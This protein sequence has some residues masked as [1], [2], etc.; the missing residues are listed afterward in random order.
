MPDADILEADL[1]LMPGPDAR[2]RRPYS[3]RPG[4]KP[5]R[6]RAFRLRLDDATERSP[7]EESIVDRAGIRREFAHRHAEPRADVHLFAR[8]HQ[9]AGLGQLAVDRRPR[10]VFGMKNVLPRH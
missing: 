3:A 2:A 5:D 6:S 1:P 9:P 7:D 4:P 10:A 8:L